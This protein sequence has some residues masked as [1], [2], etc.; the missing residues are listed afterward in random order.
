MQ[1]D[2]EQ[3]ALDNFMRNQL[4]EGIG[5]SEGNSAAM[6]VDN[7][8]LAM[9][10]EIKSTKRKEVREKQKIV[11]QFDKMVTAFER[12]KGED[13]TVKVA[14]GRN[15]TLKPETA[16]MLKKKNK[17]KKEKT[18]SAKLRLKDRKGK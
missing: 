16:G 3:R 13:S 18:L 17:V 11:M 7:K 2:K 10:E 6:E 9:E 12:T 14:Q 8:A 5:L 1:K 4:L 15:K